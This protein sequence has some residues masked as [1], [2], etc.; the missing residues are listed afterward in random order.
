[1]KTATLPT[2]GAGELFQEK[3][4]YS[5]GWREVPQI[6]P[7]GEIRWERLP[8]TLEDILHPKIGDFRMHTEE[9]ER[10]CI[11]LYNVFT[12]RLA[13]DSTAVVLH[14]VR[15]AWA[16]PGPDA[17]GPDIAVIF[18]VRQRQNWKTFKE[19]E[20]GTKP[21]VIIEV[22][23]PNTRS[24][25]LVDKVKEYERAGVPLYVIVDIYEL[26]G[27]PRRRLLGSQ[28]TPEGYVPLDP[29]ARGWLWLEPVGV[30]VGLDGDNVACYDAEDNW[31]EDYTGVTI[32]RAKAEARAAE[33][34]ARA[35][36]AEARLRQLEAELRRLRGESEGDQTS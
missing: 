5:Y 22:T 7:D 12:A 4:P 14:D 35:A 28:L 19:P 29:N 15:V 8:L 16:Q 3:D 9:H 30:W 36:E 21:S 10:F 23:S 13:N 20:E 11:Y 18:N 2:D 26:K 31:I 27:G 24:V 33:A 34:E 1:M 6:L 25:D 17:H 32:A